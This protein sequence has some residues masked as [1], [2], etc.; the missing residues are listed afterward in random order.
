MAG[1]RKAFI[2]IEKDAVQMELRPGRVVEAQASKN[3]LIKLERSKSKVVGGY[4]A[5]T[6]MKM[7]TKKW[8]RSYWKKKRSVC[9][10]QKDGN[11]AF[12]WERR[13]EMQM[14]L[15]QQQRAS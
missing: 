5:K 10:I 3:E 7:Q 11:L 13:R 14:R 8:Y 1:K 6:R 4:V 9:E 12:K 2:Q 15:L